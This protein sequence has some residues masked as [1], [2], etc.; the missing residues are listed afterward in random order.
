MTITDRIQDWCFLKVM[1]VFLPES[2]RI[3]GYHQ[4]PPM[5]ERFDGASGS[6][7]ILGCWWLRDR[8]LVYKSVRSTV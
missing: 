6:D 8:F 3:P 2:D 4:V 1:L 5:R 7:R